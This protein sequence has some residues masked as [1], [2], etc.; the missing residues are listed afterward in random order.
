MTTLKFADTHNLVAF[1]A[2]PT[3][4]EGF[5]QIVDFLNANPI[6]YALTINPTIYTSCIEQFWATVK[7]ETINGEVQLLALVDGKK[8]IITESIVRRYLQLEDA[9]G[10]D[11][12][13]N[14]T[15]W[16]EFSSSM[17]SA[18]ICLATNQK[19]NFSKY[20]FENMVNNL[21]NVS[22]KFLM[23]PRFVQVFMNQQLDGL[24]SHKR[25]Y[26]TPSFTKKIFGNMRRVGKRFGRET[27]LFLTMVV[28]YQEEMGEGSTN[29]IDPHHIPTIIQLSTS[30]PQKKQKPRK[31]KRKDI[32]I[33]LK[34]LIFYVDSLS[35]QVPQELVQ[36][37]VELARVLDLEQTKT[38]QAKEIVSLKR[39]VKKLEQKKRSRT[40]GLKRLY[41]VGSSKR[42][43]SSD[44]EV[45]VHTDE[46]MFGVNDLDGDEVIVDNVDVVKTAEEIVYAAATTVNTASTIPVSAATTTTT[47][48]VITDVEITLAQALV[49]LK[50]TKPKAKG[51]IFREP[52]ESITTTTIPI[53]SIPIPSKIQDME[54]AFKLQ[55]EEEEE[56]ERLAREKAQQIKEVNIA[57]DDVQAKIKADYQLAQRLQDQEQEEL[58][59]EEKARLFVQF[60]KQRRKH[61]AAKRA[62][63]KR[64]RP[65]TRAQQ[66]S[67]MCTYLR[68]MEGWKPK[69]L[70]N[71]TE[72]VE[73]S[74]KKAKTELKEFKESRHWAGTRA[75][76]KELMEIV[77]DEEEV[78]IDV[79]P[80]AINHML[81]SFDREDLETLYKLVKAKYGST[82][83][84]EDLDLVLYGDLKIMFEPHVED[85]VW[86][87]Q[88]DY[89][90][91][92]RKL[93]DS[94]GVHSLRKQNV[95]IH[96]LVENI[97][98]FT[99]P[100]ITD[101]LN[102][103]LQCDH[104]SEMAYQLLKLLTK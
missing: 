65:P 58:T 69:D 28:Q 5:E 61:F 13:P 9:E 62:K 7:G 42:V 40:H 41:K 16:N 46:D 64:N 24:P 19:F 99:P 4:S 38:T 91:L 25:I 12:L 54:H 98:S 85:N 29:P 77:P 34:D 59:D 87:N 51:I 92:N 72:L 6:R 74:S 86:K 84:V 94:C 49:E 26:V 15:A 37:V 63:E 21:E 89:R 33:P 70:K 101:M 90:V 43:K 80:L 76:I 8:I 2:K 100:T 48:T 50:S 82:R 22:S 47:T 57:W 30:Q 23:Y 102:K 68:N 14:T 10:V 11:C 75:K 93:Y 31:P 78:V 53:P 60:L 1:L 52:A 88:S 36:V 32:E 17:A 35:S 66:R 97:Y 56:E 55:A 71:K 27:P 96:M 73:E 39:R 44:E 83:P 79:I 95:H 3:E 20:K 103:K 45:N 18:I 81:K 104:F 67:I